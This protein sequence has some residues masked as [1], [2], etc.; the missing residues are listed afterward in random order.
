MPTS[1]CFRKPRLFVPSFFYVEALTVVNFCIF[2]GYASAGIRALNAVHQRAIYDVAADVLLMTNAM[3]DLLNQE[4]TRTFIR[5]IS[6]N[7]SRTSSKQ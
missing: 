1:T 2:N 7:R 4:E 3:Q 6:K 5:D